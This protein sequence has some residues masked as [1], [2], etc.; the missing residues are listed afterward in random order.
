MIAKWV[1]Q[2]VVA[3]CII[4]WHDVCTDHLQAQQKVPKVVTVAV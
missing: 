3:F 2:A 1:L 4:N